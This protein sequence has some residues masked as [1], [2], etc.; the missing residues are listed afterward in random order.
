MS[1][2]NIFL[3]E[4]SKWI[5]RL[6]LKQ[7]PFRTSQTEPAPLPSPAFGCFWSILY[8]LQSAPGLNRRLTLQEVLQH[9]LHATSSG[10]PPVRERGEHREHP[11]VLDFSINKS[12]ET[13]MK[14]LAFKTLFS[15]DQPQGT[16]LRRAA[17]RSQLTLNPPAS[18]ATLKQVIQMRYSRI[19][20]A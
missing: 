8:A 18:H 13:G 2:N 17:P 5:P 12:I 15:K 4:V 10:F 16:Q 11:W 7:H 9:L 1:E 20:T 6:L 14:T 3:A 19:L